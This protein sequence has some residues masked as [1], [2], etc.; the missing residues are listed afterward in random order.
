MTMFSVVIRTARLVPG[1]SRVLL[2]LLVLGGLAAEPRFAVRPEILSYT[3]LALVLLIL[4]RHAEGLGSR[5]RLLPVIFLVWVNSHGLFVLGWVALACFVV[6]TTLRHKRID[7]PLL[8]WSAASIVAGLINPYGWRALAFPLTLATRMNEAN[9]FARNIGEFFSPLDY[10]RSDQLMFYLVP[11]ACF[12]ILAVFTALSVLSLW[13][14]KRFAGVLLCLAFL[15][16]ALIMVRNVPALAVACLPGA[17]WGL[18]LDRV[19]DKFGLRGIARRGVRHAFL[20]LVLLVVATRFWGSCF[21]SSPVLACG[22]RPTPTTSRVVGWSASVWAGTAW[23]CPSTPR[24]TPSRPPFPVVC[25]TIS[26]SA[27]I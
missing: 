24:R 5:L 23:R 11:V 18:S 16:L 14:Q 25:S 2:P 12:F 17:V 7:L 26:T 15:P 13:R 6:G 8:G 1:E 22:S 4:Q 9:V 10:L 3:L 20:G 19:L 21:W 27:P